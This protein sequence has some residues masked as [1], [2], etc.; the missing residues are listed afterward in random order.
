MSAAAA[1]AA[2]AGGA[3]AADVPTESKI[4]AG[5]KVA[6]ATSGMGFKVVYCG[7][8]CEYLISGLTPSTGYALRVKATNLVGSSLVSVPAVLQTTA[9]G[10]EQHDARGFD[11]D[12]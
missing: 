12:P 6:G 5:S 8:H 3:G 10:T 9:D 4:K 7:P 2:G 11:V 1:A